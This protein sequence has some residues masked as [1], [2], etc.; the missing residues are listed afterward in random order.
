VQFSSKYINKIYFNFTE[1][2]LKKLS[3]ILTVFVFV[4]LG[5][6]VFAGGFQLN[7]HGARAMAQGGAFVARAYDPSA[8]Y[9]NPAGLAFQRGLKFMAGGTIIMPSFS[10]YGPTNLNSNLESDMTSSIFTPPS[11]YL[12]N[13]WTD[14]ALKGLGVGV[15]L[16]TPYGLGSE[17]DDNWVGKSITQETTLQTF[18]LMPTVA[19][20][21]NDWIQLAQE[22]T[23]Y[24][25]TWNCGRQSRTLIRRL[26]SI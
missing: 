14:G 15:G 5:A 13:T 10:F 11:V 17:W 9:F 22:Q 24:S 23:S 19:Y 6:Q 12:T 7:E 25:P 1:V 20:M 3:L 8:I 21:I 26:I 16:V 4:A 2:H 18:Y